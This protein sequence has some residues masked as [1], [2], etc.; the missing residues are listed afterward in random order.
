[1]KLMFGGR[2]LAGEEYGLVEGEVHPQELLFL[3]RIS[4][5]CHLKNLSID[6]CFGL[7]G[8]RSRNYSISGVKPCWT[9]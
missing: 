9:S 1:M 6:D 7:N 3:Q 8:A 2:A 4:A 5:A